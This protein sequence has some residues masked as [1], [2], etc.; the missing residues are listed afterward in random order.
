MDN[1]LKPTAFLDFN[2]Q[3]FDALTD[4]FSKAD[5]EI[6]LVRKLYYWVRDSFL[7]DPYHLDISHSG[8]IAS[9][10][11]TKKRAWCV[12]KSILLAAIARKF[13]FPTKLGFAVVKNHLEI[14]KLAHYLRREEIVFHGYCSIYVNGYWV[15]C[16]PAFDKR[17]CAWNKVEP[18]EWDGINDAMF[19][20]FSKDQR[21]M[22]YLH[23]Y[24]E[25]DDVPVV[26]MN[27]EMKKYYPHLFQN[28]YNSKDFSFKHLED[29]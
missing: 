14:S 4:D 28:E 18:L 26:L 10:I 19:Q 6:A 5:N 1:F 11:L 23:F 9:S 24:G 15:K 7:Y 21:F 2:H 3:K 12:E 27:Q 8:L 29:F 22:E 17:V 20:E 13:G 25:F 16:T